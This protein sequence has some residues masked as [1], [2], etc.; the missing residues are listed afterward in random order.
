MPNLLVITINCIFADPSIF[1]SCL[2]VKSY[3]F[4]PFWRSANRWQWKCWMCM[5]HAKFNP[6]LYVPGRWTY[7]FVAFHENSSI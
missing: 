1:I 3:Y 2:F 4:L 5:S 6:L 7:S